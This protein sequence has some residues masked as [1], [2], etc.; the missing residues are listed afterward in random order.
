MD[1]VRALIVDDELL[2][3]RGL[4]RVVEKHPAV[5]VI[6]ECENG[7]E[8]VEAIESEHPDLVLL[9]IEIPGLSG[10][11]VIGKLDPR[12]MPF[13][14]FVTAHQQ[15]AVDAFRVQAHDYVLKPLDEDR[16]RR[17]LD[18]VLDEVRRRN[19]DDLQS[20]L[21]GVLRMLENRKD[22]K[23][24]GAGL[25]RIMVKDHGCIQFIE[26]AEIDWI[27]GC[28]NYVKLHAGQREHLLKSTMNSIETKLDP[29][30]FLRIHRSTIV[31]MQSVREL[32]TFDRGSYVVLMKD[33]RRLFSSKRCHGR[34]DAFFASYCSL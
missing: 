12:R 5:E 23:P 2:A 34:I 18:R 9:D 21:D 14:V 28:G 17:V 24:R 19:L 31:N 32:K 8:A 10:I 6:G 22:V 4:R 11:D 15:Y 16:V 29:D 26:T 33:S 7:N 13:I 20:R 25:R 3:R 27:E 30:V 1:T